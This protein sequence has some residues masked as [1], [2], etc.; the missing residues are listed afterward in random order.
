MNLLSIIESASKD[1]KGPE[2][3]REQFNIDLLAYE[4][5]LRCL[6]QQ[7]HAAMTQRSQEHNDRLERSQNFAAPI[8]EFIYA[9]CCE[10]ENNAPPENG[11]FYCEDYSEGGPE[12]L[13]PKAISTLSMKFSAWDYTVHE[14]RPSWGPERKNYIPQYPELKRIIPEIKVTTYPDGTIEIYGNINAKRSSHS[15]EFGLSYSH[16][17]TEL[18]TGESLEKALQTIVQFF[19]WEL[20]ERKSQ[21]ETAINLYESGAPILKPE[22][23]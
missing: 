5:E 17:Y 1:I 22:Y 12:H 11:N 3:L 14:R 6:Q 21:I 2:R 10:T 13:N 15:E 9:L 18:Y 8:R 23:L 7:K 16:V 4:K 19:V 20:Q